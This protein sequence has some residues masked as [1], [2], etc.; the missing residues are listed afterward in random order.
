MRIL[1]LAAVVGLGLYVLADDK[2]TP[3]D[4][5][6]GKATSK[7]TSK[8]TAKATAKTTTATAKDKASTP[9]VGAAPAHP[10]DSA[11]ANARDPRSADEGLL[12]NAHF[13][14]AILEALR[15]KQAA[16]TGK[17]GAG[18][19]GAAAARAKFLE[20]LSGTGEKK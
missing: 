10:L 17:A 15:A 7:A 9:A 6:N 13:Q 14:R 8:A 12:N 5:A 20:V 11:F 1:A 18:G 16:E 3:T 2:P 19:A 4:K